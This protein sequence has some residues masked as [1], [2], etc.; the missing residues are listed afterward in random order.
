[1]SV[2]GPRRWASAL[3]AALLWVGAAPAAAQ[4]GAAPI[5]VGDRLLVRVAGEPQLSDTFTVRAGPVVDLPGIGTLSLGGVTRDQL[6]P[7]LAREIGKYVR[8]PV[9]HARA[10]IW[11]GLV[12]EVAK[13]GYYAVPADGLLSDALMAA[14]G[15][16][17]DAQLKKARIERN[18]AAVKNPGATQDALAQGLTLAQIGI[19]SG[20]QVLI[21]R[22]PDTERT[23]R[24]IGLVL[25]IPVAVFAIARIL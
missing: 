16:T 8:N 18:G 12:G 7:Y 1:M 3:L 13:P 6:E 23:T 21:P 19:E 24:I 20:D 22:L 2:T 9:V 25:A 15:V 4:R 14:G 10:L 11:L 17:R 5:Q